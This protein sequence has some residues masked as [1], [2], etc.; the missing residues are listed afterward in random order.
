MPVPRPLHPTAPESLS[1]VWVI[2]PNSWQVQDV[3][4]MES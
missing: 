4:D 3:D 1:R 2:S